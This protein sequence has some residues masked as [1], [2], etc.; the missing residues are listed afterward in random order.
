M[1]DALNIFWESDLIGRLERDLKGNFLFQYSIEW[2]N[3]TSSL[4]LSIQLPLRT[5]PFYDK[6]CKTF[7][8]NL[9]PEGSIRTLIARK[10]GISETND[11]EFLKQLGGDCAG[12]ISIIPEGR[13]AANQG[14]YELITREELNHMI[15]QMTENPLLTARSEVRLSLAGAQQKLPV[16]IENEKIY[17]PKGTFPSSHIIKPP[18]PWFRDMIQNETFCMMLAK[19]IGLPVPEV[20]I[21]QGNF[22]LYIVERYDRKKDQEGKLHRI[23]Q[24]DFCQALGYSYMQKYEADGG[25]NL[26]QCF[27]LISKSSTQSIIDKKI[28]LQGIIFNYLIGNCDAHAKNLS[29]LIAQQEYKLAPLYDLISTKVYPQL[30]HKLAMKIGGKDEPEW[31][32]KIHWEKLAQEAEVTPKAVYQIGKKMAEQVTKHVRQLEKEFAVQ[33]GTYPI[34]EKVRTIILSSADRLIQ[35]LKR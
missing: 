8:S 31:I 1:S 26:K 21:W 22:P 7:F 30:S 24:E 15:E 14:G 2:L 13:A 34:L 10:L 27:F 5:E 28:L 16:Y 12:A 17:L 35:S 29:M 23:H 19:R 6:E 3:H 33:N 9:L 4:P 25:P 20:Q 32:S 18:S 11:F